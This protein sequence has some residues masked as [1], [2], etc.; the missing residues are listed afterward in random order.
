MC[1]RVKREIRCESQI[2]REKVNQG[3]AAKKMDGAEREYRRRKR[4]MAA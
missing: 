4:R 3:K 2:G 1:E